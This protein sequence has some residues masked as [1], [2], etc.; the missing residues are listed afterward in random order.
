MAIRM[1]IEEG[2]VSWKGAMIQKGLESAGRG[3]ALVRSPYQETSSN[4]L[5]TPDCV[6]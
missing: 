4:I 2:M 5:R 3:I 6:V 1:I